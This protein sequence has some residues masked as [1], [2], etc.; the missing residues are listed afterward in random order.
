MAGHVRSFV[1]ELLGTF[2]LVLFSAGAVCADRLTGGRL[3]WTGVA[4]AYGFAAALTALAFAPVSGAHFNPALTASLLAH[5]RISALKSVF[6]LA[7]QL[8]GAS[9]AAA[10][11]GA[12]LRQHNLADSPPFL[13]ACDLS[14][15]GFRGATLLEALGAFLLVAAYYGTAIDP[16]GT[17]AAAPLAAGLAYAAGALVLGPFTGGALNPARAFGPAV[18]TGHW[19]HAYVY[20]IGP[21]TGAL[22]ASSLYEKLCLE[23]K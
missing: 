1:V 20:W 9:L 13:G 2:A 10:T 22:A 8:L 17:A 5:R 12:V 6:Y 21:L 3:G 14:M 16:R 4:L 7:A 19:S 23:K 15:I 18:F 11:L